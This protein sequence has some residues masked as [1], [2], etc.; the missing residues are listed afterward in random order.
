MTPALD[1]VASLG[2]EVGVHTYKHDPSHKSYGLEVVEALK[3]APEQ[4]FKTLVVNLMRVDLKKEL[5]IVLVP[6]IT[7]ADLKVVSLVMKAKRAFLAS[8]IDAERVTGYVVGGISPLGT[9]TPL[10]TLIDESANNYEILYCSGGRRGL[11][12]SI[13]PE[14]LL[15]ATKAQEV[16]GLTNN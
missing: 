14:D 11:E 15:R 2:I 3:V 12:I 10:R 9:R 8:G 13:S 5:V 6:V 7:T 4:V 1:L 16:P